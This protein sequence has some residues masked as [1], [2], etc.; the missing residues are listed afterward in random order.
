MATSARLSRKTEAAL[1][2]FCKAA[3]VTKTQAIEQGLAMLLEHD[4]NGTHAAFA[5]Y[6]QLKLVPEVPSEASQRSSDAMRAA[7]RAKYHR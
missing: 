7:I 2:R 5:A 6:Q 1:K 3:G 4:R